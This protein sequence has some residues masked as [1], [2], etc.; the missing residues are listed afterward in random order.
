MSNEAS[1]KDNLQKKNFVSKMW[2]N[3]IV[4]I[5]FLAFFLRFLGIT[6]GFP[7]IFHP[8]EPTIIRSALGVRF[9]PNPDHFDWPHLYIYLNCLTYM[10]F[11]FLRDILTTLKLKNFVSLLFP[12]VWNDNL[13]FYLITRVLTAT[14]GSL[15]VV[16]VY[17]TGKKLFSKKV[18]LFSALALAVMPFHAHHSHF[19]LTDVPMTFLG[20]WVL[21]FSADIIQTRSWKSFL[22]AG[23]FVGLSASTK[24]NGGLL[25]LVVATAFFTKLNNLSDLVRDI[26]KSLASS[27]MA[28]IGFL[29]GTPYALFDFQTFSRTD[30]PKGAFWQFTNVG[31]EPLSRQIQKFFL[32][33]VDK[34]TLDWSIPFVALF[35]FSLILFTY[36]LVTKKLSSD[37]VKSLSIIIFPS[38]ILLFYFSGFEKNR[39]HYFLPV[40]PLVA[41]QIGWAY[42]RIFSNPL[43]LRSNSL[44]I[45]RNLVSL[46]VFLIPFAMSLWDSIAFAR[47]DTRLM[48]FN[49]YKANYSALEGFNLYFGSSELKPIFEDTKDWEKKARK[50]PTQKGKLQ[51]PFILFSFCEK[52]QQKNTLEKDLVDNKIHVIP[53]QGRK[54]EEVC[55]YKVL[56]RLK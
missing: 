10:G 30:S 51:Y 55:I 17:L 33:F 4:Y 27:A 23:L 21:Y 31:S 1:H 43:F 5:I 53:N 22:L 3:P 14:L 35:I 44:L 36:C 8:D 56:G 28:L 47:E 48:A 45:L 39:S 24:Y 34:F 42:S 38:L 11:A 40:Y 50:L 52:E 54:G 13:I 29:L 41:L 2:Q 19:S 7:F 20:A 16:P 26:P 6:H 25:A 49:W 9:N 18:G 32:A 46:L 37:E 12:L 15:T